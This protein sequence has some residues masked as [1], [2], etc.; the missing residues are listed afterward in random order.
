MVDAVG[1]EPTISSVSNWCLASR[2]RVEENGGPEE[3]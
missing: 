1:I 3:N 2:P